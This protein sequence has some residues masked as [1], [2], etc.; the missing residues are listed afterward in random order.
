MTRWSVSRHEGAGTVV[1]MQPCTS[2]VH[3]SN[4]CIAHAAQL[5]SIIYEKDNN[6]EQLKGISNK[7]YQ[8]GT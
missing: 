4:G 3:P 2:I 5:S 8:A 7:G 6:V 1:V